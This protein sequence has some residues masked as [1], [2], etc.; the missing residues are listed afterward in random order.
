M[1]LAPG[2]S[3]RK[4]D[5]NGHGTGES[6]NVFSVAPDVTFIGIKVDN[7]SS[8]E[9]GASILEGFQEAMR[10]RPRIISVSMGYDLRAAGNK[11]ATKL[12]NSLVPLEAEILA[13]V[14]A[15]VVVVFSA[16]NGHYAFPG[17]I[18]TVIS[19][20]GVFV[21]AAG[22]MQ[23]S[24]YASAFPSSIYRGRSVPDF[25]G[26]VGMMPHATYIRLPIPKG[27]E[28]DRDEAFHD[29]TRA[30][31]GWGVFSGTSAAAPQIA[32]LCALLLQKNPGLT[33]QEVKAVLRRSSRDVNAGRASAISDPKQRGGVKASSGGDGATGAG[34]VD[35]AAALRQV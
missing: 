24:N 31:D 10:H 27:S 9:A 8:P 28:I 11:P 14:E 35:A 20:G 6:A 12:P 16:G 7:D 18:P 17:Q 5:P 21:D 3:S 34:L 23:A 22:S 2:A 1:V 32:G 26:L 19:A 30:A 33:P 29:H 13:A 25:C 4:T 15:G